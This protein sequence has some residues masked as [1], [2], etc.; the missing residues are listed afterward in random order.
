MNICLY[1]YT[2]TFD[3]AVRH[4]I[5][6]EDDQVRLIDMR[7]SSFIVLLL[8][9]FRK[10]ISML[11]K[12]L[13]LLYMM[14][15]MNLIMIV[16]EILLYQREQRSLSYWYACTCIWTYCICMCVVLI[17]GS[18]REQC[19]AAKLHYSL[20]FISGDWSTSTSWSFCRKS[21]L[22]CSCIIIHVHYHTYVHVWSCVLNC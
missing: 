8:F 14:K 10:V 7:L 15:E 20:Y 1:N 4:D 13:L 5:E 22:I 17:L 12:A 16:M 3:R 18:P 19:T 6:E 9:S 11:F 21:L 2:C